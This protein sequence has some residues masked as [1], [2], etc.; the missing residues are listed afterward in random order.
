M[1]HLL[2][3]S[4]GFFSHLTLP[5]N[6]SFLPTD[7]GTLIALQTLNTT[8][9]PGEVLHQLLRAR[10]GF[11]IPAIW[12][13]A[14]QIPIALLNQGG[15]NQPLQL[16]P[17]IMRTSEGGA[18]N[19][20]IPRGERRGRAPNHSTTPNVGTLIRQARLAKNLTQKEL[21]GL[22]SDLPNRPYKIDATV[23][24]RIENGERLPHHLLWQDLVTQLRIPPATNHFEP[25]KFFRSTLSPLIGPRPLHEMMQERREEWGWSRA[26]LSRR[27]SLCLQT[28]R[29]FEAGHFDMFTSA[30]LH[31]LL[32]FLNITR[33][34]LDKDRPFPDFAGKRTI[35]QAIQEAQWQQAITDAEL[36]AAISRLTYG[37]AH[38]NAQYLQRL[39][40]GTKPLKNVR[41][42]MWYGL[43]EALGLPFGVLRRT[44]KIKLKKLK[45]GLLLAK[46]RINAGYPST[47][48]A[49]KALNK[50]GARHSVYF[51]EKALARYELGKRQPSPLHLQIMKQVFGVK[52]G[53]VE[54]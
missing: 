32:D 41:V 48:A 2:N 47:K 43:T 8:S 49:R 46:A 14:P 36:A 16:Q 20:S 4:V 54:K 28:I 30:T 11:R 23:L 19:G 31:K 26:E 27:A 35:L 6:R 12:S 42:V 10:G 3:R 44:K 21:A 38:P 40:A 37:K 1:S 24:S 33:I 15:K 50:A 22:L 25:K 18:S 52:E 39:K 13:R 45:Q 5:G 7:A 34:A 29:R 17:D 53:C 51:D 9:T